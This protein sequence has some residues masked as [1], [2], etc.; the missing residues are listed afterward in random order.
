MSPISGILHKNEK[1]EQNNGNNQKEWERE[2]DKH[3]RLMNASDLVLGVVRAIMI[4]ERG[5]IPPQALFEK[6]HPDIKEVLFNIKVW[7]N[8][9]HLTSFELI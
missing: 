4:L 6:A 8:M 3:P 2:I 9:E 7:L 1:K 5:I